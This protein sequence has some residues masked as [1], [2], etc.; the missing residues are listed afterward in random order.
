MPVFERR[1][2]WHIPDHSITADGGIN[3]TGPLILWR[4]ENET[5]QLIGTFTLEQLQAVVAH[6]ETKRA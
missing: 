2:A 4:P 6:V 3:H 1:S 5:L